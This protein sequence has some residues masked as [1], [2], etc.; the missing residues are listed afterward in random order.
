VQVCVLRASSWS[1][2]LVTRARPHRRCPWR[3]RGPAGAGPREHG[4]QAARSERDR[5]RADTRA[6]DQV[7]QVSAAAGGALD[8]IE[9]NSAVNAGDPIVTPCD[10]RW[11]FTVIC[12]VSGGQHNS[13]IDTWVNA[14][15]PKRYLWRHESGAATAPPTAAS[16]PEAVTDGQTQ[17]SRGVPIR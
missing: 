4:R 6:T 3:P 13:E 14:G 15:Q 9:G 7:S 17:S 5:P 12:T 8:P 16:T 11:P 10:T 2:P 1:T